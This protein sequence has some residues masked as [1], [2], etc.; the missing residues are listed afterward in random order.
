[1]K[2]IAGPR[3]HFARSRLGRL[4]LGLAA[5]VLAVLL[6]GGAWAEGPLTEGGSGVVREVVDGDTLVLEDG[7]TVRLVGIM[8]PK[9]PLG[10][11]G[12]ATEPLAHDAKAAL[13]ALTLGRRV[14][15]SYGGQRIDR[16]G[17]ALAHLHDEDGLW[18]QGELLR[19]GLARVYTF[20]DNT[21]LSARMLALEDETRRAGAGVWTNGYYRVRD[22]GETVEEIGSFQL[23]EG[24]IVDAANVRGRAYLN[25]GADYRSDFT[26][27]ISPRDMRTFRRADFDPTTLEGRRVRVRGWLKSLNGPMIEVTH[28][29][30]IEVLEE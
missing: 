28:P 29:E 26:I 11:R 6:Q 15:L 7:T 22:T 16:Y 25:F 2:L 10:R 4:R 30:Q 5:L 3:S 21:A 20:S 1:M 13:E 17:R 12:F 8:T 9:L 27:T 14:T 18:I 19:K 24:R 23:V